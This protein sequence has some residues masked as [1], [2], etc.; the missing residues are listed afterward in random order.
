MKTK[1]AGT[2]QAGTFKSKIMNKI[3]CCCP[4][5]KGKQKSP[6]KLSEGTQ[7][8]LP[9]NSNRL[10]NSWLKKSALTLKSSLNFLPKRAKDRKI[11]ILELEQLLIYRPSSSQGASENEVWVRPDWPFF[12]EEV[13]RDYEVVIWSLLPKEEAVDLIDLID[14]NKFIQGKLFNHDCVTKSLRSGVEFQV[15]SLEVLGCDP[16]ITIFLDVNFPY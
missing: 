5:F 14:P 4:C 13:S 3:G 16:K 6:V 11:L 15:K 2:T 8:T 12:F 7:A 1:S 9:E 10:G